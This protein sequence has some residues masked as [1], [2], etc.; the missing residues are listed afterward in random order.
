MITER[1]PS[2]LHPVSERSRPV[3]HGGRVKLQSGWTAVQIP[4]TLF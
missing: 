3:G 4:A 1:T 2:P